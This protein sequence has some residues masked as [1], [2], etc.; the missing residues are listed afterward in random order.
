M[1]LS[2]SGCDRAVGAS[3]PIALV[4]VVNDPI[5]MSTTVHFVT[6]LLTTKAFKKYTGREGEKGRGDRESENALYYILLDYNN[7]LKK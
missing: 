3:A 1:S 5:I 4:V 7:Y 6:N 2:P